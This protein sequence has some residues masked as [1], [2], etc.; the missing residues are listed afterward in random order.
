MGIGDGGKKEIGATD[1][2]EDF[3]SRSLPSSPALPNP[4][5]LADSSEIRD[6]DFYA[7]EDLNI[8][9]EE[10][11][12]EAGNQGGSAGAPLG[13]GQTAPIKM[14]FPSRRRHLSSGGSIQTDKP[15]WARN[16]FSADADAVCGFVQLYV[17]SDANGEKSI[18]GERNWNEISRWVKYE[19]D[20]EEGSDRLGKP[21]IAPL[22]HHYLTKLHRLIG[23]SCTE[24][25]DLDETDMQSIVAKVVETLLNKGYV[26]KEEGE[27]LIKDLLLS[28]RPVC[29]KKPWLT[30]RRPSLQRGMSFS[31]NIP[32][33]AERRHSLQRR[34]VRQE[35]AEEQY[36]KSLSPSDHVQVE[37]CETPPGRGERRRRGT[38]SSLVRF[39]ST[40]NV[41]EDGGDQP[42][43]PF[44]LQAESTLIFV[45]GG[46]KRR[47]GS[48]IL[49]RLAN[50]VV[51][52]SDQQ[53][54]IPTRF[55]AIILCP[56]GGDEDFI[57][58]GKSFGTL[59]SNTR[60]YQNLQTAQDPI[61]V[62]KA[63]NEFLDESI[64]LPPGKWY[65]QNFYDLLPVHVLEVKCDLIYRQRAK[66]G[67]QVLHRV[68]TSVADGFGV[69]PFDT[70]PPCKSEKVPGPFVWTRRPFGGLINDI[71]RRFPLYKSDICDGLNSQTVAATIFLYFAAIAHNVTFG[72]LLGQKTNGL[73]GVPET[74]VA[75]ALSGIVFALFSGQPLNVIAPTGPL[76]VFDELLYKFM[77]R[78]DIEFLP[79]R[80]WIGVWVVVI[81]L[82]VV[83]FEGSIFT[84]HFS[85][86][87]ME[88]FSALISVIFAYESLESLIH[89]YKDHPLSKPSMT[90]F[91]IS[92]NN[93]T[94]PASGEDDAPLRE[95]NTA[96]LST[97][98]MFGTFYVAF[99]LKHLRYSN[100]FAPKVRI[101]LSDFAV[102][103]SIMI[104]VGIDFGIGDVFT[105]KI[106]VP[107]GLEPTT[108]SLR[109]WIISPFGV[110]KPYNPWMPVITILPGALVF[111]LMFMT[112]EICEKIM[113]GREL[114]KG[115]GLHLDPLILAVTNLLCGVFGFP[116]VSVATLKALAHISA[117]T[118]YSKNQPPGILPTVVKIRENRM[119]G[120][121]MSIMIG[122]SIFM[123]PVLKRIPMPVLFGVFLYMGITSFIPTQLY[124]RLLLFLTPVDAHP[125]TIYVRRVPTW[126]IHMYTSIQ[127]L[128][129]AALWCVKSVKQIALF[130]PLILILLVPIRRSLTLFYSESELEALDG[131][132]APPV[133]QAPPAKAPSEGREVAITK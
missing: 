73:I 123:A 31:D 80:V 98:L 39:F 42:F 111:L 67:S 83:G 116:W 38:L 17:L 61:H 43:L 6:F 26:D 62:Q 74:L 54:P 78:N 129:L 115:C 21:H 48:I 56:V 92:L 34:V 51:L 27:G 133:I 107:T 5:R 25:F 117:L 124:D 71:K 20:L 77:E 70:A 59:M 29:D 8:I 95:P 114:Q 81:A 88:T 66:E 33:S 109:G 14:P 72:G 64:I 75:A 89:V 97:F 112:V 76:L 90:D 7:N 108:P 119:S 36:S 125:Q 101:T 35:S 69:A 63:V 113:L 127:I 1:G 30:A 45:R 110:W 44:S 50:A 86:F 19:Q 58:V 85:R 53:F 65:G 96:L 87:T 9:L 37:V 82:I 102:P 46:Y 3:G 18:S 12:G 2:G 4:A 132:A 47:N 131:E 23:K 49:V 122:L 93:G 28:H 60:F 106:K 105:T 55:I 91:E 68:G 103:I 126:K 94:S 24:L 57:E 32:N 41:D 120:L 52:D 10:N 130:F 16:S 100:L 104:M 121:V 99:Q 15:F 13:G 11:N 128:S 79:A 118:V 22:A 84:K 40:E